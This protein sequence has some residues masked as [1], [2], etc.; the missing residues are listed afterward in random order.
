MEAYREKFLAEAAF[1]WEAGLE[2]GYESLDAMHVDLK[3]VEE[4]TGSKRELAELFEFPE[5]VA[6][7]SLPLSSPS[8]PS[9][10]T[11]LSLL[12]LPSPPC[13]P[14]L[15]TYSPHPPLHTF[16]SHP[17]FTRLHRWQGEHPSLNAIKLNALN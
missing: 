2:G 16:S 3:G 6:E 15:H 4:E 1:K 13:T 12:S 11:L 8:T 5:A 7:P 10:I 17:L 14:S 9:T